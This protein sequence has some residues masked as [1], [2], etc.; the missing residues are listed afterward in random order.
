[1]LLIYQFIDFNLI[2]ILFLFN[3]IINHLITLHINKIENKIRKKF[4]TIVFP[5]SS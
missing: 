1:M 4:N 2:S 3:C 5:S